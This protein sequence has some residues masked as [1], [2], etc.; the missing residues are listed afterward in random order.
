M[1]VNV[2]FWN[3]VTLLISFFGFLFAA[4]KL[5]LAQIDRRLNDRFAAMEDAR[6]HA[7]RHW[8]DKFGTVIEQQ[9]R[10]AVG[11][12]ALERDFLKW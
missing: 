8:D 10:Q 12:A 1:T 3:L 6:E 11:Q 9:Q 5:L 7:S 4:G 2:D